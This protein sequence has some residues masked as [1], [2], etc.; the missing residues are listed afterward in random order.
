MKALIVIAPRDFQDKEYLDT[1]TELENAGIEVEIASTKKGI[2]VGKFG[3]KVEAKDL[4]GIKTDEF[5]AI[6]FIGGP[7]VPAVRSDE[8]FVKLAKEFYE[9]GKIV[10]AICWAPTILAKAG[11]LEG[12]KAT[13][14]MG[15]DPEYGKG[16]NGVLES[17]GAKFENKAVVRDGKIITGNGPMAASAFGKE[18]AKALKNK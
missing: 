11:V 3:A 12:K 16:T 17:F 4:G 1:R 5:D 2:A 7:G 8:R 14:W 9:K 15:F 13:V 10:C 18:I 6:V